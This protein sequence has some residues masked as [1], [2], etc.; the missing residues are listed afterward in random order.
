MFGAEP[1]G[2]LLAPAAA[3]G[4]GG[5]E[6]PPNGEEDAGAREV[7]A[8][9][10]DEGA[11]GRE[12]P[13]MPVGAGP[14]GLGEEAIA[15]AVP[16]LSTNALGRSGTKGIGSRLTWCRGRLWGLLLLLLLKAEQDRTWTFLCWSVGVVVG[17]AGHAEAASTRERL[18]RVGR[19][20]REQGQCRD[21][22]RGRA[23][24]AALIIL[25]VEA[26]ESRC[27]RRI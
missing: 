22:E 10:E 20:G 27:P 3:A 9:D 25:I 5:K 14:N 21:S 6:K 15:A 16:N 1:K 24:A 26:G 8:A 12:P 17:R 19:F 23:H 7:A 2:L 11:G 18:A 4:L 13:R